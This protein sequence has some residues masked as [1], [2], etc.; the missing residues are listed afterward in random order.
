MMGIGDGHQ[1]VGIIADGNGIESRLLGSF[2]N[3]DGND[4]R[5]SKGLGELTGGLACIRF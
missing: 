5:E 4:F 2:E 1:K 3:G